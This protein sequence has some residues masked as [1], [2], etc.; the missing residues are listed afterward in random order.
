MNRLRFFLLIAFV[1]G[2]AS[3]SLAWADKLSTE[4][5]QILTDQQA[6]TVRIVIDGQAVMTVDA[7]GAHVNGDISY[8]GVTVDTG[9]LLTQPVTGHTP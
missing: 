2:F 8:S 6:G 3:A 1:L 4:R 9:S 7:E 5:V